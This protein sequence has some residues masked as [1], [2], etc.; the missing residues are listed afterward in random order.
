MMK[1][2]IYDLRLLIGPE[3]GLQAASIL[4]RPRRTEAEAG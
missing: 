1:F 3:R 2:T 4:E